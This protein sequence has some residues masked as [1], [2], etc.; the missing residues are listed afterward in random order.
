MD[1]NISSLRLQLNVKHRRFKRCS[2]IQS[3]IHKKE[4]I[5]KG[6]AVSA[7]TGLEWP[8]GFQEVKVPRFHDNG[9]GWW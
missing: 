4:L 3:V 2:N 8:T 1:V 7:V 6:K 5:K 9:R